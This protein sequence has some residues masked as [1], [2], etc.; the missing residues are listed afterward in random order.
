MNRLLLT[1]CLLLAAAVPASAHFV[2]V[3]PDG[4]AQVS[5][6]LSENL[7]PDTNVS[8]DIYAGTK[9]QVRDNTGKIE[10]VTTKKDEHCLTANVP[11]RGPRI[12]FGTAELGVR[13][14]GKAKPFLLAY[15]PKTVIGDVRGDALT[16]GNAVPVEIVPVGATRQTQFLVLA[17]GKPVANADV[18]VLTP[19]G[20]SKKIVTNDKGLTEVFTEAGRY[21]VWSRVTEAKSGE[22]DGKKYEE[23]RRYATLVFDAPVFAP[24][25]VAVA[26]QG[27]I[28]S[29]GYLYVYGGHAGKTHSYDTKAVIGTFQRLKL[30]TPGAQW[31][32][33][34]GGPIL[35]GMNLAAHGGKIYRVG[36]MSPRNAPGEPADNHSLA[37]AVCYNPKTGKWED[38][39]PLPVGRSSHELVVAGNKLVVVGGWQ[40]LGR[41]NKSVWQDTSLVLDLSSP[42][43]KWEAIPQPFRR[44]ALTAAAVGS[45]VYVLGGLGE[46]ETSKRCDILDVSTGKWT[47][48]PD[49]PG[50]SMAGFS[51]A[52]TNVNGKVVMNTSEGPVYQLNTAGDAWETIG[53]ADVRRLVHRMVPL[54]K[55]SVIL[56]GGASRSM[57]GNVAGLEVVKLTAPAKAGK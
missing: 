45:K 32:A 48:G 20:Q 53:N 16:L 54:T 23:I 44:R 50:N 51:P 11:A 28:I 13:A 5:V 22:K 35:Q 27:T 26:S 7:E 3:V 34:P 21:G 40:M 29:D 19:A 30:D 46:K 42:S 33:L 15:Y 43:P 8:T 41:G 1:S 4:P 12:V 2:Y 9:L 36:G 56:V 55:D 10:D 37:D 14:R 38:L 24:L 47:Q 25:P 39:P 31:E 52:A 57:G 18:T 49:F 17:N 6:I